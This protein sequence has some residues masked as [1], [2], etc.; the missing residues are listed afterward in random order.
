MFWRDTEN[1]WSWQAAPI[2][3][4]ALMIE[5]F[6]EVMADAKAVEDYNRG[7]YQTGFASIECMYAP[8]FGAHS[9]SIWIEAE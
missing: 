4:H 7:H 2:E 3:T 5:A 9:E 8:E 1:S 6:D